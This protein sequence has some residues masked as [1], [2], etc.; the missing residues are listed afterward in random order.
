MLCM[1]KFL[2]TN[3]FNCHDT[4][5]YIFQASKMSSKRVMTVPVNEDGLVEKLA[6]RND[7]GVPVF[8]SEIKIRYSENLNTRQVRYSNG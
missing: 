8:V 2:T 1:Y 5:A 7:K 4:I 6:S 3:T